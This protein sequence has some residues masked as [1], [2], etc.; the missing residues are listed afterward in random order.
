MKN[1]KFN[2]VLIF[3]LGFIVGFVFGSATTGEEHFGSGK[4][5]LVNSTFLVVEW[6]KPAEGEIVKK[7]HTI[8]VSVKP[9]CP[10]EIKAKL[11]I[12]PNVTIVE[13]A[14]AWV[15]GKTLVYRWD[16]VAKPG[17]Y[18]ATIELEAESYADSLEYSWNYSVR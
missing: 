1:L 3:S 11:K 18:T 8:L 10:T 4:H 16:V 14:P 7:E 6:V 5:P 13:R 17:N 9:A 2:L 12:T 15:P